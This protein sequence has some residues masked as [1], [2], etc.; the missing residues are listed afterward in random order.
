MRECAYKAG[1][2]TSWNSS[3]LEFTTERMFYYIEI[4]ICRI[5]IIF[6]L[7]IYLFSLAEAA[8][9]HCL[10]VVKEHNLQPGGITFNNFTTELF[11]TV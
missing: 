4:L 10:S 8:A 2:L 1:L 11:N 6:I 7:L 9:L 3:Q 5:Y